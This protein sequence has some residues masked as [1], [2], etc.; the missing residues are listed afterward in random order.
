MP[1]SPVRGVLSTE[2]FDWS[3][4]GIKTRLR[5]LSAQDKYLAT[6]RIEYAA[7]D[8]GV[9]RPWMK[10]L[11]EWSAT[12]DTTPTLTETALM[13][14]TLVGVKISTA[15][16]RKLW[17]REDWREHKAAIAENAVGV[18][19][20]RMERR[21]GEY[22]DTHYEAMRAARGN[23]GEDPK[24]A[25]LIAE[26]ILDRVWPKKEEMAA[27]QQTV[28]VN[29]APHQK[30]EQVVEYEVLPCEIVESTQT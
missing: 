27:V 10:K 30:V 19:R 8:N 17:N 12:Q 9:L 29:L 6:K 26:P 24:T 7:I 3:D 14:T 20:K 2:S 5:Y 28:I 13:A 23:V 15:Y 11:A 18:A 22:V 21:V 16:C 4:Q 25:A 1:E